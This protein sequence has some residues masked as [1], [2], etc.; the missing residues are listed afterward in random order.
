MYSFKVFFK[1]APLW[2]ISVFFFQ[3]LNDI[4]D[5]LINLVSLTDYRPLHPSEALLVH[6]FTLS[7]LP[8]NPTVTLGFTKINFLGPHAVFRSIR[9][10]KEKTRCNEKLKLWIYM[11]RYT[12]ATLGK[13]HG[14]LHRSGTYY[15]L[16]SQIGPTTEQ[17][18]PPRPVVYKPINANPW[19][20][21]IQGV[22]FS[23]PK[24][25]SALMR[26]E[27][28]HYKKSILKNKNKQKAKEPFKKKLKTWNK[29]LR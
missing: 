23:T 28:L 11:Y 29:S 18:A 15:D 9:F 22:Y 25:C 4:Q 14:V 12:V 1:H 8:S 5:R 16:V 3:V 24:C 26:G 17:R 21:N 2:G 13:D 19:L 7:P 20:K 10:P 6:W 27:T